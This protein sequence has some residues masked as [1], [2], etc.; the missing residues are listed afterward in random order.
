MRHVRISNDHT[1]F[2]YS[3][4]FFDHISYDHPFFVHDLYEHSDFFHRRV[5]NTPQH[6]RN[7]HDNQPD[8]FRIERYAF[9]YECESDRDG[10]QSVLFRYEPDQHRNKPY[11]LH[12]VFNYDKCHHDEH[13]DRGVNDASTKHLRGSCGS[14][15]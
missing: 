1:V 13:H 11:C 4:V 6:N 12:S 3:N 7:R 9:R 15:C 14:K 10:F 8:S 2:G 5:H